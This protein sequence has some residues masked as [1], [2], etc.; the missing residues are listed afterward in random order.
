MIAN[1]IDFQLCTEGKHIIVGGFQRV[2]ISLPIN[3]TYNYQL[4][5]KGI[6]Q[7]KIGN[8][9][10]EDESTTSKLDM[11]NQNFLENGLDSEEPEELEQDHCI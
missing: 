3:G 11:G 5:V 2:G 8:Q 6:P 9:R 1:T 10:Q 4:Q 7:F